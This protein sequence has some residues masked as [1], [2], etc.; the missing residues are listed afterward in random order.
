MLPCCNMLGREYESELFLVFNMC[1]TALFAEEMWQVA[2]YAWVVA[3]DKFC[4][5]QTSTQA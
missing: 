1:D 3:A 5:T 2:C 4:D